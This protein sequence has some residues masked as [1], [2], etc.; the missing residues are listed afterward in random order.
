MVS[1]ED[2]VERAAAAVARRC[3]RQVNRLAREM[4]ER[5]FAVIPHY[6]E[7]PGDMR[8]L[9]IADT[10]R[11]AIRLFLRIAAG[12]AVTDDDVRPFRER[13][14]QR[15]EEGVPLTTLLRTYSIGAEVIWDA[16]CAA[17]RPGEEPAL[18]HLARLQ[19]RG[20]NAVV[21]AVTE[22][23][24]AERAAILA[25][26][27]EAYREVARALLAGEP[28]RPVAARHAIPLP[29]AFLVLHLDVAATGQAAGVAGRRVLRRVRGALEGLTG[30]TPL[31]LLDD[32]GGHVL[33]PLEAAE[34]MPELARALTG[35]GSGGAALVVGAARA[36]GAAGVPAAA[37]RAVR[38]TRVARTAGRPPGVYEVGDVLLEYH[39]SGREDSGPIVAGLLAPLD[40]HPE[41]LAT[42]R[43]F[44][45]A[46]LDRR[47]TARVLAVHPNTVDNRLARV[48]ALLGVDPRTTR[49]LLACATALTVRR[50][51]PAAG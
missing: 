25:E 7:L 49:G 26:R 36:H 48:G 16:L 30:G 4:V 21:A 45:D 3:E 6:T 27:R 19:L 42:L 33:L 24:Q 43:A 2:D 28:A 14:A 15:A 50:L 20:L 8:E 29:A 22:A 9:E 18:L 13:A 41:L 47:E 12:A 5:H 31:T 44:L 51:G 46:D 32:R 10:A 40:A 39:L 38:V 1:T 34:R 23:Y 17:A 11:R 37:G 35:A